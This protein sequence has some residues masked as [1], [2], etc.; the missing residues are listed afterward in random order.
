[1]GEMPT[2]EEEV[3]F[4]EFCSQLKAAVDNYVVRASAT[5]AGHRF[6]RALNFLTNVAGALSEV[7]DEG[8][9]RN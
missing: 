7:L 8:A 1:M 5:D 6:R 3:A 9:L 2:T 4:E